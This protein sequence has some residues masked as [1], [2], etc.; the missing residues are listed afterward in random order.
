MSDIT[1]HPHSIVGGLFRIAED[2]E[3]LTEQKNPIL[4][5]A[6]GF[7]S[8]GVG[9]GIYLRSWRDFLIPFGLLLLVLVLGIVTLEVLSVTTPFIWA[10][11]GYRRVVASNAKLAERRRSGCIIDA[12]IVALPLQERQTLTSPPPIIERGTQ[13]ATLLAD[14]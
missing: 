7:V 14:N 8:G 10:A 2:S 13:R 9:L 11:Y 1:K 3:P 4:A 6:I 5:A 12:E